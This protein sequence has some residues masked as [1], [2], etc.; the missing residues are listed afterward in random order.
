MITQM[1]GQDWEKERMREEPEEKTS[2]RPPT[3][4]LRSF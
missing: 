4:S 3:H 2:R 1:A